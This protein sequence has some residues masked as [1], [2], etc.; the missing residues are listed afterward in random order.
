MS[1]NDDGNEGGIRT[2]PE[3]SLDLMDRNQSSTTGML[4]AERAYEDTSGLIASHK[5]S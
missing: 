4:H 5:D 3:D 2:G 1:D